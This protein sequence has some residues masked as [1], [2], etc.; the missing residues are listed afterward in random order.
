MAF[1]DWEIEGTEF[2]NCSCDCGCPCQFNSLPTHGHCRA[3]TFVRVERGRYGDVRLDGLALRHVRGR[4]RVRFTSATVRSRSI[5]DERAD[6]RQRAALEAIGQGRDTDPGTLVWQ[7]FSTTVTTLLAT[8]YAAIDLQIDIDGAHRVTADSRPGRE[9]RVAD[10]E[11]EDRRHAARARDAAGRLRVHRGGVRGR[12]DQGDRRH[13]ARFRIH[14]RPPRAGPLV[15]ARRGAV[16]AAMNTTTD[17]TS[18]ERAVM[19][20]RWLVLGS[21]R[22][23]RRPPAGRGSCR[24]PA[25]CTAT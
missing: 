20:D 25:T 7:V 17:R 3:H 18:V 21:L 6:A 11:P 1:T 13:P 23:R 12:V 2:V 19:R 16:A 10:H 22:P 24:W 4:G 15:H 14:A 8:I 5:V 9:H